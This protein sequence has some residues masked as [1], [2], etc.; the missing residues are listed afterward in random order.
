MT[1]PDLYS[2]LGVGTTASE[3]QIARAFRRLAFRWHPDRN[4]NQPELAHRRF[5]LVHRAY[6][7]LSDP[8][9]RRAWDAAHAPRRTAEKAPAAQAAPARRPPPRTA[10][11]P[12]PPLASRAVSRLAWL[13]LSLIFRLIGSL[14]LLLLGPLAERLSKEDL[15]RKAPGLSDFVF[16]VGRILLVGGIAL[17]GAQR[18][19]GLAA[20]PRAALILIGAGVATFL[21]ERVA[22][23]SVWAFGR[24]TRPRT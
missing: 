22:L 5:L 12:V 15:R 17:L 19:F 13:V 10:A 8:V 23:A 1:D 6:E 14:A 4:L 9:R 20:S 24:G 2:V 18:L 21:L 7:V 16:P 3:A 11:P